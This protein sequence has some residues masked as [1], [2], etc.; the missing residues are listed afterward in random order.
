M[1]KKEGLMTHENFL[2]FSICIHSNDVSNDIAMHSAVIDLAMH[3]AV[4]DIAALGNL[5]FMHTICKIY[6]A[7]DRSS[8]HLLTQY[9]MLL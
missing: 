4:T 2:V 9:A 1:L 8:I 7:F 6:V 3:D 5:C